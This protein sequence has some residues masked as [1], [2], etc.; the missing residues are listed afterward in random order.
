MLYYATIRVPLAALDTNDALHIANKL[1][2]SIDVN[3][4]AP[5]AEVIDVVTTKV[6]ET[7]SAK[8]IGRA[9]R[10]MCTL[11][12]EHPIN[13]KRRCLTEPVVNIRDCFVTDAGMLD[14]VPTPLD[15]V[16][17]LTEMLTDVTNA[18]PYP[19]AAIQ[20]LANLINGVEPP[21]E[22][23]PCGATHDDNK[24]PANAE[25]Q[26]RWTYP[27]NPC[28]CEWAGLCH[29]PRATQTREIKERERQ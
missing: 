23:L 28:P 9:Y 12:E 16:E 11:I 14:N 22:T 6:D 27:A 18:D 24:G 26:E 8:E 17:D 13:R 5:R 3:P 10:R 2:H 29:S 19:A 1:A 4:G 20:T 7:N 25:S 15:Q 21:I